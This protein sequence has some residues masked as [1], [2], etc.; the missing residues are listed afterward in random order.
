MN[1]ADKSYL[2]RVAAIGC[3]VCLNLG[4]EGTPA[5]IHHPRS[6]GAMGKKAPH[7][8]ALPLCAAHHRTG[9]YGVAIH[10]GQRAWE[11]LYGNEFELLTQL[12]G[13]I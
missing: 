7:S 2:S 4:H 10:A 9:G 1:K 6:M 3:L 13:I 11:R 8:M 12:R 5:E